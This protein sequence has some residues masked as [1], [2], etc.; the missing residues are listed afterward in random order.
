MLTGGRQ[1]RTSHYPEIFLWLQSNDSQS[2]DGFS[3]QKPIPF[4]WS[5]LKLERESLCICASS[6]LFF[7]QFLEGEHFFQFLLGF[8]C[9]GQTRESIRKHKMYMVGDVSRIHKSEW[10]CKHNLC[11]RPFFKFYFQLNWFFLSLAIKV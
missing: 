2:Y 8:F 10:W 7:F 9:I 4:V 11:H 6:L 3:H 1:R 5:V